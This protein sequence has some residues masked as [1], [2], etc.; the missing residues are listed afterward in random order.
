[1]QLGIVAVNGRRFKVTRYS[2][3]LVPPALVFNT[4]AEI[5][6]QRLRRKYSSL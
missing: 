3:R 1:M 4:F 5:V 2:F 6:R